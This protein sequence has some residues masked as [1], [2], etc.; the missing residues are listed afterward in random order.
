MNPNRNRFNKHTGTNTLC[1][2]ASVFSF[3]LLLFSC[4]PKPNL[5]E[6]F[7]S[8][9]DE[10][11][12][13]VFWYWMKASASKEGITADLE[14][15]AEAGIG[16]AYLMPIQGEA[17][18][19]LF[20][21]S[22]P[23]LS[24]QWWE[25]VKHALAEAD[26]LGLKIAMHACDGFALA[27]GPWI[28]PD[29]SMQKVVWADT[30]VG[31]NQPFNAVLPQP[32]TKEGYYRDLRWV[33]YPLTNGMFQNSYDSH[34]SVTTSLK[35]ADA[36]VLAQRG[37]TQTFRSDDS[38]WVQYAFAQS[39][40]CRT[41]VVHTNGNN[42]QAHRLWVQ[43]SNDGKTFVNHIRLEAP[44][45]GWQDTD[46]GV[47]HAIPQVTARWFRFVFDK[48]GTE[49]GAEDLDAAKWRPVLRI[50]GIELSSEPRIHQYEGKAALA[51]R[52]SPVTT[53]AQLPDSLCVPLS[54]MVDLSDNISPDSRLTWQVPQGQW[55]IVRMGHT[56]TG[57]TNYTGGAALGLEVDKFNP[58]AV[59]LQFD[60]W[61]GE[62]MKQAG[63]QLSGRVL[64][65]FHVDSWEC[66]SQNWSPVFAHEFQKRRG[67]SVMPYLPLLAGI[68]IDNATV[69]EKVLRDIR[70][71]IAE[72]VHDNFYR[73]LAEKC[74]EAGV[75]FTAESVAPTMTSD[76]ILHYSQVDIPMGEFWLNSPTHDKPN[77]MLDATSGAHIYGKRIV[78]AEGFTT[79][80][81][82]WSEHPA[83]LKA[84]QDRNYAL[85]INR[86]VYHVF[87]HNPWMDRRPGMTLDGVGLYFQRDQTWWKPGRE[88]VAY[89]Q[90][91]QA[92]L[93]QGVPVADV[94]VFIG[95]DA[96]RRS[97]LPHHLTEVLPGIVGKQRVDAERER[98]ANAGQP[99][100]QKPNG[101][102]HSANMA[103]PEDWTNPL[104][105][106][107]YDSFNPDALLRL[108]KV[109]DGR[110]VFANGTSYGLLVLPNVGKMMPNAHWM[111]AAV[112]EK[113]LQL[114]NDGAT[115]LIGPKPT[116]ATDASE[117]DAL[118]MH[119]AVDA[120][121]DG[122]FLASQS[123]SGT[124]LV[125]SIGK[126]RVVKTPYTAT[127]FGALGIA[128]DVLAFDQND[129]P[130][131]RIAY[132]HRTHSNFDIYFISNQMDSARV[133]NLSLRTS[134]RVP[135]LFD[136]V[137]GT[138]AEANAWVMEG[139]RTH[140]PVRLEANGSVFVVF[141]KTTREAQRA[142][143]LNWVEPKTALTLKG[144]WQVRFDPAF[145]G[146][147][148][149][150]LTDTLFKWN[151]WP[152][153]S[154]R[155]YSGSAV[156]ATEFVWRDEVHN[157]SVFVNLGKVHN[158]AEV[159]LNGQPCGVA[160]TAPWCIDISKALRQGTNQLQIT[161]T[162][163]WANRL[164]GDQ[165]VPDDQRITR[166]TAPF[167]LAGQPLLDAGL[168]GPVGVEEAV[169][170]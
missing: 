65:T 90:R 166:T 167:R 114:V 141:R 156:Y 63:P 99:V 170:Y 27:G 125:K 30:V 81:M 87:A 164:M 77:D 108:A 112:A 8:P 82:D 133:M 50:K 12:P 9:P 121:W 29:L 101:V 4:T 126:G 58:D 127:D 16:G 149:P 72:L 153:Q 71:T 42:Y 23:Q 35:D 94:G 107:A 83:M 88:W 6:L 20:E 143:G 2:R 73:T 61:F 163:T 54:Q 31:G 93:Q 21:P 102:W 103:L 124:M 104:N 96:P 150:V 15:M 49:P 139:G 148:E 10:T 151:H 109:K 165:L 60:K 11:K 134:G 85:G 67:Y 41:V 132:T 105:G 161:V 18:P 38:C 40:T 117:A 122:Q 79:V 116:Q 98:L 32:E 119:K 115:I 118:R 111:S 95:E 26:R 66:G 106:Y 3:L 28:T 158:M 76:G 34:P 146:P 97:V 7:Q 160:W 86:M 59:R 162:N 169:S 55:R 120:L 48:T 39:F 110:V 51:W 45:H 33:A 25:L 113:L 74:R 62:A 155:Y 89:A 70:A 152:D 46:A 168:L 75:N 1:L 142:N 144:P 47:T 44:R 91:C 140:L 138:I 57:H 92:L 128:P 147:S 64:T 69:S 22:A 84:L 43:V 5:A 36:T 100:R 136:P 24:P 157:G 78:Q 68:P 37:N 52:V 56:S 17:N 159:T 80:R 137:S 131:P 53:T 130:A 123:V 19:P 154:I 129:G 14:A 135:E 13:W 145:G